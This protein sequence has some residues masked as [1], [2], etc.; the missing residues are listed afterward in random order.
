MAFS[1]PTEQELATSEEEGASTVAGEMTDS[2]LQPQETAGA[3]DGQNDDGQNN[4]GVGHPVDQADNAGHDANVD[5]PESRGQEEDPS[6]PQVGGNFPDGHD[7]PPSTNVAPEQTIATEMSGAGVVSDTNMD[8]NQDEEYPMT[9]EEGHG[10]EGGHLDQ[11][12]QEDNVGVPMF[13]NPESPVGFGF[14]DA[15]QLSN[16]G[17]EDGINGDGRGVG[18]TRADTIYPD[19]LKPPQNN[20]NGDDHAVGMDRRRGFGQGGQGE[21]DDAGSRSRR[22]FDGSRVAEPDNLQIVEAGEGADI[23][24]GVDDLP[25]FA[26]DQSK[27]LNDEIKVRQQSRPQK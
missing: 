19:T 8:N 11:L 27:A 20:G 18:E 12:R 3:D 17:G 16:S 26:N 24:P 5:I 10:E 6:P 21:S 22:M 2:T 15:A 14:G 1:I 13:G 25:V 4:G 7:R 9:T 23:V